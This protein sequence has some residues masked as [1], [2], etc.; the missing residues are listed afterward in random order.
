MKSQSQWVASEPPIKCR[1]TRWE[2]IMAQDIRITFHFHD[3]RRK[4]QPTP[5]FLPG[6]S[7][8]Q[9]SLLGCCLWGR[10]ESDTTPPSRC[11]LFPSFQKVPC[12]CLLVTPRPPPITTLHSHFCRNRLVL[13]IIELHCGWKVHGLSLFFFF[14]SLLCIGV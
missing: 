7:Q 6:E 5:V 8:G 14:N 13:S 2:K 10:T 12:N 1:M 11:R 9:R 4:W 3:W